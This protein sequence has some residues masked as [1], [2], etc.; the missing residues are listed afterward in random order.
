MDE[1][2]VSSEIAL[3]KPDDVQF[4]AQLVQQVTQWLQVES[5][6]FWSPLQP[7]HLICIAEDPRQVG[8]S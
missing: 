5:L 7:V 4:V 8:H 1:P 6:T 2:F 3:T